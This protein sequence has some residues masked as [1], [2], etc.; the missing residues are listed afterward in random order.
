[1]YRDNTLI[2]TEAIRLAALGSLAEGDKQYAELASEIRYFVARITGPSLDLL[3]SSLELL[4]YEG[5]ASPVEIGR[6]HV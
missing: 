6:A 3:G 2:P 5:L 1:M 4:H